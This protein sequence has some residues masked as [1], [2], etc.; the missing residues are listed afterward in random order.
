MVVAL[1]RNSAG[2]FLLLNRRQFRSVCGLAA[3]AVSRREALPLGV[4]LPNLLHH[5]EQAR[6]SGDAA[7][8]QRRGDRGSSCPSPPGRKYAAGKQ[9]VLSE[10]G[11]SGFSSDSSGEK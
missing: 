2:A 6:P 8:F 9:S 3:E 4:D 11:L 10:R 7:G 5:F 1:L